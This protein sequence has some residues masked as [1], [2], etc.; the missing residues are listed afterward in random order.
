MF[1]LGLSIIPCGPNLNVTQSILI[2]RLGYLVGI[3]LSQLS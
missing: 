3:I 2:N 1:S